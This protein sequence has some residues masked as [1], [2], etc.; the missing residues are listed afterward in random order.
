M[1]VV[2]NDPRIPPHDRIFGQNLLDATKSIIDLETYCLHLRIWN[3]TL[4][5]FKE[6]ETAS[7]T[8]RLLIIETT[9][10]SLARGYIDELHSIDKELQIIDLF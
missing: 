4:P 7:Q 6:F 9:T 5:L 10:D 3:E 8:K 2:K 1:D